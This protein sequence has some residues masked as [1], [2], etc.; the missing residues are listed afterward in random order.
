ML[1]AA[2]IKVYVCHNLRKILNIRLV[3]RKLL[4]LSLTVFCYIIQI[5]SYPLYH[6]IIILVLDFL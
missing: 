3:R 5:Q 2:C 6:W 4:L 1:Y